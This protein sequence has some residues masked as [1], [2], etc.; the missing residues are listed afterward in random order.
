MKRTPPAY[1]A[2]IHWK[3]WRTWFE[4]NAAHRHV[5]PWNRGIHPEPRL[6]GPLIRSL[7]R[8]QVGESG[9]GVHLKQSATVED[10][11]Y[12]KALA[13]FIKEEQQH[14]RLL[15]TLLMGMGAG[16]IQTHWSDGCFILL[17]RLAGLRQELLMLLVA[18]MIGKRYY[19]ALYDGTTDPVLRAAFAQILDDEESHLTFH[20]EYLNHAFKGLSLPGRI[21]VRTLWR[22]LF[23]M[24]CL[25]VMWD[26]RSVLKV[27]GVS[28][29]MF[30]WDCGLIF[31]QLAAAILPFPF[32]RAPMARPVAVSGQPT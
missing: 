3:D 22:L 7:Q 20:T 17:R 25:V 6:R 32:S 9:E 16:L 26:H 15:A 10:A 1:D 21:V 28:P 24:A 2:P 30:W 4:H 13:L 19:Q 27:A 12:Q 18:E 5:I 23:R 29:G 11:E 8:F 14:A 31:D